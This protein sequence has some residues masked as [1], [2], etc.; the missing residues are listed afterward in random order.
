MILWQARPPLTRKALPDI[1]FEAHSKLVLKKQ[2][3]KKVER[4]ALALCPTV[5]I[6][7]T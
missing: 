2:K 6:E 7:Y 5:V 3:K 4:N 1:A